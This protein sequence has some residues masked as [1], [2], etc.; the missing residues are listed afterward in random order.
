MFNFK[1]SNIKTTLVILWLTSFLI[2]N[3]GTVHP[4]ESNP[5]KTN[6]TVLPDKEII[7]KINQLDQEIQ[8]K[9]QEIKTIRDKAYKIRQGGALEKAT[10]L[11][12]KS[13]KLEY[14]LKDLKIE[15]NQSIKNYRAAWRERPWWRQI[16]LEAGPQYT[17]FDNDLEIKND[18]GFRARLHLLR[19]NFKPFTLE[20]IYS[21]LEKPSKVP[22]K[23]II[24]S[25]FILEYRRVV[26]EP[27]TNPLNKKVTV[28]SYLIGYGLLA[29][30]LNK[31]YL[32]LNIG[33]GIQRYSGTQPSDTGAIFSYTIGF[34][35]FFTQ[36]KEVGLVLEFTG[37][38]V[39]TSAR[40]SETKT[41]INSSGSV[42]LRVSF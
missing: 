40:T 20:Y 17:F 11:D 26:T 36:K 15:L 34:N 33:G 27:D 35:Q 16:A 8:S 37:D 13:N 19:P 42:S 30:F 10:E 12:E 14:F 18:S 2:I 39:R 31:S 32:Y 1:K 29:Q 41:L 24:A 4:Q 21:P 23:Q 38:L 25:P 28:N 3:L 7:S 6:K 22:L 9:E 5:S